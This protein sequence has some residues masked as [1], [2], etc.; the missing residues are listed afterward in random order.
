MES[1]SEQ[2]KESRKREKG[3]QWEKGYKKVHAKGERYE[4]IEQ[5][6]EIETDDDEVAE[7]NEQDEV[8]KEKDSEGRRGENSAKDKSEEIRKE[9]EIKDAQE[10]NG[11]EGEA[12][13]EDNE[14]R[15][16]ENR[17]TDINTDKSMDTS[18]DER[19]RVG[20]KLKK[21]QDRMEEMEEQR[22]IDA[23]AVTMAKETIRLT[24]EKLDRKMSELIKQMGEEEREH[25]EKL[26]EEI[27][28]MVR[29]GKCRRE[30]GKQAN[31][32]AE[33]KRSEK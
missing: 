16:I 31:E 9:Q 11:K 17:G 19:S 13:K 33:N 22:R 18:E 6:G 5:A 26:K 21:L 29:S 3:K 20:E 28:K 10:L 27:G 8:E 12:N 4:I 15:R 25:K 2:T 30:K 7:E 1:K 32:S 24:V 14:A 23:Q